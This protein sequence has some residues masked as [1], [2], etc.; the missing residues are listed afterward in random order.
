MWF[1]SYNVWF[2]TLL[3]NIFCFPSKDKSG[4]PIS[5]KSFFFTG[6]IEITWLLLGRKGKSRDEWKTTIYKRLC[7]HVLH[8]VYVKKQLLENN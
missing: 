4:E 8:Y 2:C 3:G 5:V 6:S 1:T 7:S